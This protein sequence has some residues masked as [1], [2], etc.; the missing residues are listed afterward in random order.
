MTRTFKIF[1]AIT[2]VAVAAAAFT[3][4]HKY[5]GADGVRGAVVGLVIGTVLCGFSHVC[6]VLA[7]R[8]EE[9][10]TSFVLVGIVGGFVGLLAAII[11]VG[12]FAPALVR[13]AALT[14]LFVYLVHRAF[15]ATDVSRHVAR[16][17]HNGVVFADVSH[18]NPSTESRS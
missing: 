3:I 2:L 4:A 18:A 8:D 16:R 7:R 15:E 5:Q 13:A 6:A 12:I 10:A 9:R 1:Q 14:A 17:S 11:A